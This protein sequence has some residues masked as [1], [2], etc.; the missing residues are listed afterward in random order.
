MKQWLVRRG[1]L[2]AVPVASLVL[3]FGACSSEPTGSGER[4]ETHDATAT[5][6]TSGVEVAVSPNAT[7]RVARLSK[8][9]V[10]MPVAYKDAPVR[11]PAGVKPPKQRPAEILEPRSVLSKGDA[12]SFVRH[13]ERLR[14]EVDADSK[15][16]LLKPAVVDVPL[17]ADGFV[18][19]QPEG[20]QLGVEFATKDAKGRVEAEVADGVATYPG[21]GP[22]GSDLVLRVTGDSV[23][24]F[25]VLS[26]KPA[27]PLVDYTI[28][29]SEVA[30]L[31]LFDNTLE[32]LDKGGDPQIRVKPPRV[33][34]V[35]G[36]MHEAKLALLDCK[37]DTN[38]AEPWGRPVT[39]PGAEQCTLRVSW[40]DDN[41]VYPAIVDPVWATA[42]SMATARYRNAA[43]RLSTGSVLTCGGVGDLG[44]ALTS[45]E[46]FN[47]A[48][49]GGAGTW[50]TVTGMNIARSDHTLILLSPSAD[51]LAVGGN[52]LTSS[53]RRIGTAWTTTATNFSGGSFYPQQ[54]A[55]TSDGAWVVLIDS[56]NH[57]PFR[58]N[59]TTDAWSQGSP[60]PSP[61][62]SYRYDAHV[63]A[64]PGQATIMRVGGYTGASVYT[65]TAERYRPSLDTAPP[66]TT[67]AWTNPGNAASMTVPR[68]SAPAVQL[69]NNRL[70]IM[71]GYTG[72]S[73]TSASEI[74]NASA[75]T[76]ALAAGPFPNSG[77]AQQYNR[78]VT[79]AFHGSGKLLV[80]ADSMNA[81]F[82]YDP[83]AATA[84][85][86]KIET[87]NYG[88]YS[89]GSQGN[90]V[91]AGS[92]VLMV[93]VQLP[94]QSGAQTACRLFDFGDKGSLCTQTAECQAGLTCV[95]DAYDSTQVC[96]DT[97]C[98]GACMS[99]RAT[100]KVSG[101]ADGTCGPRK[102]G[103]QMYSAC[104][105][106]NSSTCGNDNYECDGAGSCHKW[107]S[108][109]QC[110]YSTCADGDT[111]T[112]IRNCDG[113]GKCQ[114]PVATDCGAGFKCQGD[115]SSGACATLCYNDTDYCTTGYYCQNWTTPYNSCQ[116]KKND[117]ASCIYNQECTKG[118]CVDGVC[119]ESACT[120]NCQSCNNS[121]TGQASGSCKPVKTGQD[122][123]GDCNDD[124]S[125]SCGQNGSCNGAGVCQKYASGTT[126]L[127]ASCA[128][129]TARNVA[130]TCNGTGTCTD[131]GVQNC[132]AGYACI[133]GVCQTQCTSDDQCASSSYC[134]IPTKQ[135]VADKTSG[136]ACVRDAACSGNANCVDGVCCN[137]SCTG[138]CRSCVANQTGLASDGICGDI[139]DDTDPGNEC[140]KDVGYPASCEAPGLCDG[141]G[142]CRVYAKNGV[143]A[144]T[145]TCSGTTLSVYT[146]DGAGNLDQL[147]TP[148]YPYKCNA[149]G[150]ACRVACTEGTVKQDCDDSSFCQDGKCVGVLP[151]GSACTDAG[152][153]KSG[154]CADQHVGPLEGDPTPEPG[155]GGEGSVDTTDYPGVCCDAFCG[156][157]CEGCKKSTKGQG[158][159]GSCGKVA[160][161]TDL[162]NDC[163][164]DPTKPCGPSGAC[165][166]KG[167]CSIVPEGTSCGASSCVGN[168]ARGQICNGAGLCKNDAAI[169][170]APYVCGDVNGAQQCTNPCAGDDDCTDGYYCIEQACKK[171]LA[172][173]ALCDSSSICGSGFCVDG[174]CCDVSCNGQCAACDNPGSEG[175]CSAVKG[176]PHGSRTKCDFA[177]EEC[178]GA[179]DGVNA[180]AC[181]YVAPGTSC[182]TPSCTN[183]IAEASSCD[184][185]GSCRAGDSERCAP[186]GCGDD[187][188]CLEVCAIDEDCSQGY[189]CDEGAQQ[190]VPSAVSAECSE[191][192][193]SSVGQ[194]GIITPCKPFLCVPASGTCA[195]SCAFTT[196]CA[197]DF[198]CEASTKTCLPAPADGGTP[199]D[200]S[201]ACRAAG[202]GPNRH[203]YLAVAAF[204]IALASLRRRKRSRHAPA[205]SSKPR[206]FAA[207]PH[208]FE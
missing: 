14:A 98:T 133:S 140:A 144:K 91:S 34:D 70:M 4:A 194:Q 33:V 135:C 42:G 191:D 23:E 41:V 169:A 65:N 180:S 147:E 36:V 10:H 115:T 138:T 87:Y 15:Q 84:P 72:A 78:G 130:D 142:S 154:F 28:K 82:V 35:D 204:G 56:F 128:S 116:P 101:A 47:P 9:F 122:P 163:D 126:C 63:L 137:S 102:T 129:A 30:G 32:F 75:N 172:N 185:Q 11:I 104:A 69:D 106:E 50:A 124:G 136:Q 43:V 89:L 5:G 17:K 117:G 77:S 97:T 25:V 96:C 73:S 168:S 27:E 175:I 192:R 155:V 66:G 109:T 107:S 113:A 119:C 143:S 1:V 105:Y 8:Q 111:Q 148:C 195:V 6:D 178:G 173:G 166:G 3:A 51:V 114:D 24:D 157:Q 13:G 167:Q 170:C 19:V 176:D 7:E 158:S 74:Y 29:T 53:E 199:D 103:Q 110:A 31:R 153:C 55:M 186:Y 85:W 123:R 177:G 161:N 26:E 118:Y 92:K 81:P 61:V 196:D 159:D 203:G 64:I 190:C 151:L 152:Q 132:A 16:R 76:W 131:N 49:G 80:A 205:R 86:T 22:H 125:S 120:G 59:T 100:N 112:N 162:K 46:S 201:C 208:P 193:Q 149:G 174:L 197:P 141:T 182:G 44:I 188:K 200:E 67:V 40:N 108:S 179:C 183:G 139:L 146:C 39:A 2:A 52:G 181:K 134:D 206:G 45:C 127:A 18:R 198:V 62:L 95:T 90:V 164:V 83:S 12:K 58:Y 48:G 88:F 20:A 79:S 156:S 71:G 171:K 145:D 37:A 121:S 207:G 189:A 160:D 150:T 57:T 99:C 60:N 93:P 21:A 165:D 187:E 68:G 54:P 202:A 184:G 94:S 38:G